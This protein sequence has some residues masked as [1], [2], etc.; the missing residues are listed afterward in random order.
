MIQAAI[1]PPLWHYV[2]PDPQVRGRYVTAVR[3]DACDRFAALESFPSA[4]TA[5]AAADDYNARLPAPRA[6]PAE[7]ATA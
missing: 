4:A 7:E 2:L 5:Q 6:V 1:T 3:I